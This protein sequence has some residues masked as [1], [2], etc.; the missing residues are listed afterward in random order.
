MAPVEGLL[1]LGV[2]WCT[3][4]VGVYNCVCSSFTSDMTLYCLYVQYMCMCTVIHPYHILYIN[5]VYVCTC[6]LVCVCVC[7][8]VCLCVCVCVCVCVYIYVCMSM[9]GVY[10]YLYTCEYYWF[11]FRVL[12]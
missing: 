7:V 2:F 4:D 6:V 10:V 3:L 12:F 11:S 9:C 1:R 8:C 5:C